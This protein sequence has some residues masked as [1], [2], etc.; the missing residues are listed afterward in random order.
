[1]DLAH[2]LFAQLQELPQVEA[3]ALGGSRASGLHDARSDYDVYLYC[4]APIDEE[5]RRALLARYCTVMEIGNHY[6]EYEDNCTFRDGVDLDLLHRDLDGFAA[7]V[8]RVVEGHEASLGYTTCMWHNLRTCKVVFDRHSRLEALQRRFDV[9]YPDALR[10][11]IIHAN[12]SLLHG[13]LPAYDAQIHKAASRGDLVSVNHRVAAFLASYFDVLF[14][15]NGMTHP[16]EKRQLGIAERDCRVL[17]EDFRSSFDTLF[18]SMF[19][20]TAKL[21]STIAQLARNLSRC[22]EQIAL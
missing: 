17:P 11:A 13:A 21:D 22:V 1:M 14:A 12:M 6:W 16:G 10:D 18:A 4:T 3:I 9:P 7:D 5:A 2:Q 8:R 20:D 15:I 19:T